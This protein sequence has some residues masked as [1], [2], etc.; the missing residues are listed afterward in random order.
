[1]K[2][3]ILLRHAKSDWSDEVRSDFDRP[4]NRRGRRAAVRVGQ[5]LREIGASF[6]VVIA[7]PAR[8]VTETIQG[9]EQGYGRSLQ[10]RYDRA[11]YLASTET[12]LDLVHRADRDSDSLLIVGHNP[13]LEMLVLALVPEQ[14]E[15][16]LR[17]GVE[18]KFPTAAMVEIAFDVG[19]W[20]EV[21]AGTG[22]LER[23][24]RPRD[25]DPELGPDRD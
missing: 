12:L 1:M 9:F 3:L 6:D 2:R 25:L 11:V 20:S 24:I 14:E 22:R 7:S 18:E 16:D 19:G 4:L 21:R 15:D 13:G 23:F 17:E 10:A 8:R 5:E